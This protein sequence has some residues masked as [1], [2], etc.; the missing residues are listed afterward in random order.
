M[1]SGGP[2]FGCAVVIGIGP[3][4]GTSVAR[5][6]A[7]EGYPV[8][9]VARSEKHLKPLQATIEKQGGKALSVCADASSEQSLKD[10]FG[11]IRSQLGDVEVLVYNAGGGMPSWPPPPVMELDTAVFVNNLQVGCTGAFVAIKEVLPAMT[12]HKKGT[13]LLT[14]AT[15]SLRG[16]ARF[17]ALAVHKF[18]LRALAQCVARAAQWRPRGAH[19]D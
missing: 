12:K 2:A 15:A 4:L 18:A 14:G 3:G 6:F 9:L 8:A 13:I 7:K 19:R 1:A 16:G 5:K 17:A 11:V 10:A